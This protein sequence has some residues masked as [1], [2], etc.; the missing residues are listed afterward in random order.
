MIYSKIKW[1]LLIQRKHSLSFIEFI[2]GRY[3]LSNPEKINKKINLM[4]NKEIQIIKNAANF[5]ELWENLWKKSSNVKM[6]IKEFNC[7]K[8]K[9]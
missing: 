4:S 9:L 7:T 6:Y 3:E 8:N 1:F 2:R 5:T